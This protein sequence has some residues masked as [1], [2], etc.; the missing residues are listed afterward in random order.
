MIDVTID[1]NQRRRIENQ[2]Q[3][4]QRAISDITPALRGI[5]E[6][7]KESTQQR[8][9]DSTDPKGNKWADNAAVTIERKGRNQP[10]VAEGTL[11]DSIAYLIVAAKTLEI[12]S[13]LEY[14]AMMQFGGTKAEFPY[15]WG[16]I[17]ARPYLGIS[18]ADEDAI[19]RIIRSH[20]ETAI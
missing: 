12:S 10:L 11:A 19:T 3:H 16:D 14:A 4:L 13:N 1:D 2:L 6:V 5:G 15:L 8:F 17:P 18:D 7:L 9:A 20:L